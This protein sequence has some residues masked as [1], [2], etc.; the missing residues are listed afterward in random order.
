MESSTRGRNL[1]GIVPLSGWKD[2]FDF[3]WPDYM[4][5]LREGLLAVERS[6]YECAYAG[7]DSI[8]VVCDDNFAPL[9]KTRVGDYVMSPRFF[10]EKDFVKRKDYHEK[11]IPIYYTPISQKDRDRRD[12]IGWSVLHGALTSFIISDKMSKW[13]R[14]TKYFVSFPYGIYNPDVVRSHR[15]SIRG[16][17]SFY[18]SNNQDTVR[19][20]KF[21]AFTFFPEDW[22][23]FKW[24]IK[25]QCTG[26]DKSLPIEQRWSSQNFTLDKIFNLDRIEVH[27]KIEVQDYYDLTSWESLSDFYRS[28][29]KI[30]RPSRKF[31]KPYI[32]KKE[33]QNEHEAS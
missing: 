30:P 14:P 17:K 8:W 9:V 4:Q 6:I 22:P 23:Q 7:C 15:D 12:S 24:H 28:G 2:T 33:T 1:A 26:G 13:V 3:P 10:E 31:M 32:F 11:W 27:K 25:N 18:L 29:V 16:P 19:D 20:N 21:L 5:P